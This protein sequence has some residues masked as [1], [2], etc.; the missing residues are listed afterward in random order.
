MACRNAA[1]RSPLPERRGSVALAKPLIWNSDQSSRFTSPQCRNVLLAAAV[2]IS[3]DGKGRARDNIF[4][5]RLWRSI[6][7]EEVYPHASASPW[8]A[9][10]GLTRYLAF[11]YHVRRHQSRAYCTPAEVY[12]PSSASDELRDALFRAGDTRLM[13]HG[14]SAPATPCSW[15][16]RD[17][18]W[19]V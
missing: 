15:S 14:R 6:K 11:Y 9:R 4:V 8:E 2:R 12:F 10:A 16:G 13:R 5:E 7:Y 18:C 17:R 3:M 1:H 19:S